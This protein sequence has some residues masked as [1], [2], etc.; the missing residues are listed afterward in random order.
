MEVNWNCSIVRV[1]VTKIRTKLLKFG[2]SS[3][4]LCPKNKMPC[5]EP[6]PCSKHTTFDNQNLGRGERAASSQSI[7]DCYSTVQGH[8]HKPVELQIAVQ[9]ADIPP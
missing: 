1:P 7:E 6:V 2:F 4:V 9:T 3:G 5:A 8:L